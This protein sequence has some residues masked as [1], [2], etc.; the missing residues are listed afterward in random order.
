MESIIKNDTSNIPEMDN[1]IHLKNY[2][3]DYNDPTEI[4][5]FALRAAVKDTDLLLVLRRLNFIL[6][7]KIGIFANDVINKDIEYLKSLYTSKESNE[8]VGGS[9][10][11]R[12]L[13]PVLQDNTIHLSN[14]GY[15]YQKSIHK[16]HKAL[17]AAIQDTDLLLVL[18][19]L[20]YMRNIQSKKYNSNAKLTMTSDVEYLKKLYAKYR[21]THGP[22]SGSYQDRM[23]GGGDPIDFTDDSD[24]NSD[25]DSDVNINMIELPSSKIISKFESIHKCIDDK[26]NH[27]ITIYEKHK[28][29]DK[30]IIF[31]NIKI[32][33]IA[34]LTTIL[35]KHNIVFNRDQLIIDLEHNEFIGIFVNEKLEGITKYNID[36]MKIHMS[37]FVANKPYGTTFIKF[38]EK[39]FE[40]NN[41]ESMNITFDTEKDNVR[42]I[43][44]MQENG[45]KI[46]NIDKNKLTMSR[47]L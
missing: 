27:Y 22:L 5:H 29:D 3:Y 25:S 13:L 46:N 7:K 1:I 19:R 41:Y 28:S 38:L 2:D 36:M 34:E 44:L 8:A 12:Q 26:C 4:R 30:E 40:K 32:T 17:R 31:R 37:I 42:Y 43:N 21:E 47:F 15:T 45:M 11:S 6:N 24:S 18:R 33:D 14:Y 10:K 35:D 20:N 23:T 16:R 39:F 9:K